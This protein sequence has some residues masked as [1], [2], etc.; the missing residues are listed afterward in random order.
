MS[1]HDELDSELR[2]LFADDRLGVQPAADARQAI[3]AGAQRVRR[4]RAVLTSATGVTLA[5]MMVGGAVTVDSLH[6]RHQLVDVA[7]GPLQ[8]TSSDSA[9]PTALASTAPGT[10]DDPSAQFTVVAPAPPVPT[11]SAPS[12]RNDLPP[13]KA[14]QTAGR[15]AAA[16]GPELGAD[17]YGNLKLGM[18]AEQAAAQGVTL[19]KTGGTDTCASFDITGSGVPSTASVAISADNGLVVIAPDAPVH[20]PEGIGQGST[21]DDVFV[22]YPGASDDP[23]TGLSAP[24]GD[25][26]TYSFSVNDSR[27]VE[28]VN[29]TSDNQDCAG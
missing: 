21:E 2:R 4:R 14:P 19:T 11:Q 22:A 1:S 13:S 8:T 28:N 27:Q 5:V 18:T 23:V 26:S 25:T 12:K 24:A 17:G 20:T 7:S 3:V 15:V 6:A 10:P 29:L 9:H 16:S